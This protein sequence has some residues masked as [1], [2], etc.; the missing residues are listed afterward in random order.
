MVGTRAFAKAVIERLGR[1]PRHF[2]RAAF[3]R[4][5]I[6]A[7]R[8]EPVARRA[9]KTLAGVDVFLDAPGADAESLGRRVSALVVRPLR[10]QMITNRGVKVWPGGLPETSCTDHWR[11]RLLAGDQEVVT[12]WLVISQLAA[13]ADE[14][15]DVI[16]TENL[17]QFDGVAGYSL[18][19]GQ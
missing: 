18:G 4:V 5:Q 15:L 11:L 10:L 1:P 3:A 16:K 7:A 8:A 17:F 13:L 6:G 14:G 19:Q 12:P 9:N 2:R